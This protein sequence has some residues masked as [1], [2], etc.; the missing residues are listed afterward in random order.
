MSSIGLPSWL[1]LLL[2]PEAALD[3]CSEGEDLCLSKY[4]TL[5]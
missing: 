2:T 3:I 1:V 5:I 4:E